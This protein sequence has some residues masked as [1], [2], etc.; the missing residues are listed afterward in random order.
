MPNY[1]S[2]H[3]TNEFVDNK[4]TEII[5]NYC[6]REFGEAFFYLDEVHVFFTESQPMI[7]MNEWHF[8]ET[9][10]EQI[11]TRFAEQIPS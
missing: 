9:V 7:P 11:K 10:L 3:V 6:G 2:Y 5:L 8:L 1:F 4:P